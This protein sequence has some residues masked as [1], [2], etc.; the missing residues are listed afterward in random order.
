MPINTCIVSG[1]VQDLLGQNVSGV[2]ISAHS[3]K[4]FFHTGTLISG[5]VSSTSS[6]ANGD[7]SLALIETET[8]GLRLSIVFEYS[9]GTSGR[10]RQN[11]AVV[12][13][14]DPTA[15]FSDLVAA[16]TGPA[17]TASFPAA[18]VSVTPVG[19]L[20][21]TNAQDA[22]EDIQSEIDG[23]N[24][25]ADGKIYIGDASN[26]ASEV[27]PSG[28]VTITNLGVT[29]ISAGVIVNADINAGAGINV[30]K[31]ET[32][33]ASKAIQSNSSGVLTTSV[34]TS[35]ELGYVSGV[36]SA[37][38][39]QIN[40][41]VANALTSAHI[42]V[43]NGSNVATDRAV[44]GDIAIDNTGLTSISSGV[45]VNADV[46]ASAAIDVSKLAA[47]TASKAVQS[48]A[49]GFLTAS[50][51]TTTELGYVAGVTSALQTQLNA[52]QSTTLT[53]AH[54]LVGNV[55]NLAADVALTGDI[56][57][58]NTGLSAISAGVIVDADINASAAIVDTKLATISTAGK[59]SNSATTATSANT[60]SAI[61]ARDGSGNFSAGTVS[62]ALTGTASGNTTYSAN[63]FGVVLSGSGNVMTVLA[64]AASITKVLTSGG[65]GANPTW[66]E[67]SVAAATAYLVGTA[68]ITTAATATRSSSP[69]VLGAFAD[70][71]S[72]P[73]PVVEITGTGGTIQ[74]TDANN[75]TFTV[76][77]LVAGT[78]RVTF[79]TACGTAAGKIAIIRISD[80]TDTRGEW[81]NYNGS[82]IDG[83]YWPVYV[84][85]YFVYAGSGNKTFTLFGRTDGS[86]VSINPPDANSRC[87]FTIERVN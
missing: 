80:G 48:D 54:I 29:S 62:A 83:S 4:P 47:M 73:A 68:S 42:F 19:N 1:N 36:T 27:T 85:G 41:L 13:P 43:G 46:N 33:T 3:I 59:V 9:N 53:S 76:N 51:V 28:D 18:F 31:L 66:T 71:A 81:Q 75:F 20:T 38:Q 65:T 57:I 84:E 72:I 24:A 11:Y 61:V 26:V 55:S 39:T 12:I 17:V 87:V 44:T 14:D 58:D 52:K 7:W 2:S 34:V 16:T 56:A 37:I 86:A 64:P 69:T 23:L 70:N 60:N 8:L 6:D 82:A 79:S 5:Q 15:N 30:S 74:T 40:S 78:Y 45:I 50:A 22:L 21:A 67:P 10:K 35:T 63:Q 77:S 49:S 32:L 25:L